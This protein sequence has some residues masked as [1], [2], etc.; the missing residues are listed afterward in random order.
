M[1]SERQSGNLHKVYLHY[2]LAKGGWH[3]QF[4]REDLQ[5]PAAHPM[6][7]ADP[8]KVVEMAERGGALK[9]LAARQ[10]LDYGINQGRGSV[11]LWLTEEQY[12][13]LRHVDSR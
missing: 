10:A 5:T 11:W 1:G 9:D 3:C 6:T 13:K 12:G 7:F 4:L 2:M 8:A